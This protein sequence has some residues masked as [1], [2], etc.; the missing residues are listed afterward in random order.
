VVELRRLEELGKRSHG[1]GNVTKLR[2]LSFPIGV[3]HGSNVGG[4][5]PGP[6]QEEPAFQVKKKNQTSKGGSRRKGE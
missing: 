1:G 2:W 4:G 6:Y 5:E 3:N